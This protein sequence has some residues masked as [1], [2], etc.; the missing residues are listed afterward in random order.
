M[1]PHRMIQERPFELVEPDRESLMRSWV[2]S[3]KLASEREKC[4][5]NEG[6]PL[7]TKAKQKKKKKKVFGLFNKLRG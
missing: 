4:A 2:G 1:I 7:L 6:T 3:P 5:E